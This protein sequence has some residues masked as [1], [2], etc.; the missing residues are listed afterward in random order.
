MFRVADRR[1]ITAT[2]LGLIHQRSSAP[3]LCHWGTSA[4]QKPIGRYCERMSTDWISSIATV[5]V[6]VGGFLLGGL[7]ERR[8]DERTSQRE[9]A[10]RAEEARERRE[11]ERHQFQLEN[12]LALQEALRKFMRATVKI[13]W[14]D[15]AVV[16]TTGGFMMLQPEL[17]Q[18]AFKSGIR[19]IRLM[20]RVV[21]DD[22]RG[23]L[24][25]FNSLT[26]EASLPPINWKSLSKESALALLDSRESRLSNSFSDADEK[27]GDLLRQELNRVA[28]VVSVQT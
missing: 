24:S 23:R 5:V 10:S 14:A 17:S 4:G 26:T 12:Y 22:L 6:G 15:R 28:G 9:N 19:F 8:R 27:L 13:L 11:S 18:K 7:N 1:T 20:N 16:N 3:M 21:D 2:D 25:A